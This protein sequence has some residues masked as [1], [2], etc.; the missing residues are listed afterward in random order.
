MHTKI[1][2]AFATLF[3]IPLTV[4][5]A[6]TAAK[7]L[8]VEESVVINDNYVQAGKMLEI[9]GTINGDVIVAAQSL[10]I[11]GTVAGDV[12]AAA[13]SIRISG[14]VAGNLRLAASNIE[15]EGTVGKNATVFANT[16]EFREGSSVGW[17]VQSF[18]N[19][20][21]LKGDIA[22]KLH[23][24]GASAAID[25]ATVGS[26]AVFHLDPDGE[27]TVEGPSTIGG[28]LVY[29][30]SL[31]ASIADD[32]LV[33]GDVERHTPVVKS[34]G[35]RE[36]FGTTAFFMKIIGI[37]GVLVVGLVLV[38]MAPKTTQS[39]VSA[40]RQRTLS[41]IGLGTL[42]LFVIPIVGVLL[43]CTVIGI[44]LGIIVLLLYGIALYVT[45][46]FAG[47]LV[48]TW[49]FEKLFRM[50]GAPLLWQF[51]VGTLLFTLLS[52]LPFIG[53]LI[54]LFATV[55]ALGAIFK[56]KREVLKT[57]EG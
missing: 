9:D 35:L 34:E 32:V 5:A 16:I 23:F 4:V 44:P 28:N 21:H 11:N 56:V 38:S 42:L 50:P 8:T 7:N 37:F 22:G 57:V 46:V 25:T 53:W 55:C 49:V 24:Y 43:L 47:L 45:H 27:L 30:S 48:G 15:I 29:H 20:L 41:N 36:F 14:N 3:L 40:M 6:D 13:Q 54:V 31:E 18:G 1:I 12:I 19:T 39:V 33:A 26:D 17:S 52:W 51:V 2:I 10:V